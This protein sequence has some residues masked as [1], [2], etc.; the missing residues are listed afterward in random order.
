MCSWLIFIS[1]N[2]ASAELNQAQYLLVQAYLRTRTHPRQIRGK[3]FLTWPL[4]FLICRVIRH[5]AINLGNP[6]KWGKTKV[7]STKK[8]TLQSE[9]NMVG[10][11][12]VTKPSRSDEVLD[13][14]Q[15]LQI[16]NQVRAQFDSI[17]P[18]RP[19]K[20][21]RSE[22]ESD[23]TPPKPVPS[24]AD[25]IPELDRLRSLQSQ[26]SVCKISF[27]FNTFLFVQWCVGH[28]ILN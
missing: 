10:H 24:D 11:W 1:C 26:S 16:A 8:E 27:S 25:Q 18:K 13:T 6:S 12:T 20:P 23:T 9:A 19:A 15:Q 4:V 14:D 5:M 17:A 28:M 21:N 2:L 3:R 7:D 22:S